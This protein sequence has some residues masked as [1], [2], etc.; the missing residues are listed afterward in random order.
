VQNVGR[1]GL[2]R[3]APDEYHKDVLIRPRSRVGLPRQPI[4]G[5]AL[6]DPINEID[7]N[8]KHL[9]FIR[10][11]QFVSEVGVRSTVCP[12]ATRNCVGP[13]VCVGRDYARAAEVRDWWGLWDL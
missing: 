6:T 8:S 9:S 10:E 7:R 3:F 12:V 1:M 5:G 13:I 2:A 11:E 4:R